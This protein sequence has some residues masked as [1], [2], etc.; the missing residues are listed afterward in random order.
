MYIFIPSPRQACG[1]PA[2]EMAPPHADA[3]MGE[4]GKAQR[5]KICKL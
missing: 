3:V 1:E 5:G 4:A 2:A